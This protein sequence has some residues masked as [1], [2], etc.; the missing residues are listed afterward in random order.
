VE[1]LTDLWGVSL[2]TADYRRRY[3]KWFVRVQDGFKDFEPKIAEILGLD[4]EELPGS[5]K[6]LGWNAIR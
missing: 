3:G 6:K 1:D 5:V 4:R 2:P